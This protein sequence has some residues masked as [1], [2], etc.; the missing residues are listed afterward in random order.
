[1]NDNIAPFDK[2]QI[3]LSTMANANLREPDTTANRVQLVK[4]TE[5]AAIDSL[6][7][8]A[9][10]QH[11]CFYGGL[12]TTRCGNHDVGT[13][14]EGT[15]VSIESLLRSLKKLPEVIRDQIYDLVAFPDFEESVPTIWLFQDSRI[16]APERRRYGTSKQDIATL[17]NKTGVWGNYPEAR[18]CHLEGFAQALHDIQKSQTVASASAASCLQDFLEFLGDRMVVQIDNLL[19]TPDDICWSTIRKLQALQYL[20]SIKPYIGHIKHV[21]LEFAIQEE[22]FHKGQGSKAQSR[23][24]GPAAHSKSLKFANSSAN[25][26]RT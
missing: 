4:P 12:A 19:M 23:K 22:G 15:P 7:K 24:I 2:T 8:N 16:V 1:M 10:C 20:K 14:L 25:A 11:I 21:S 26:S 6:P 18:P 3:A 17:L 13:Y 9:Y 5:S